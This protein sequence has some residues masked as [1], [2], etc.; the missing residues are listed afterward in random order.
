[1]WYNT[2]AIEIGGGAFMVTGSQQSQQNQRKVQGWLMDEGWQVGE[3]HEDTLLWAL[4]AGDQGGRKI[5]VGQPRDRADMIIIQAGVHTDDGIRR[6][7]AG[8]GKQERNQFYFDLQYALLQMGVE[9]AG[10]GDPFE[11]LVALQRIYS[12]ALNRDVFIQRAILV[13]NAQVM[14]FLK[15]A[16]LMN[17]GVEMTQSP[18]WV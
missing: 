3:H 17:E 12:E 16:A 11:R 5:T 2:S 1:M 18:V 9:Y 7:I 4:T 8:M 10:I 13:R 6:K 15:I 14:I